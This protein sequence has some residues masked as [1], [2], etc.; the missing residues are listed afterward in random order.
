M[1]WISFLLGFISQ[2]QAASPTAQC[3]YE[4]IPDLNQFFIEIKYLQE[5]VDMK[6]IM[7]GKDEKIFE[8]MADVSH[9]H[10]SFYSI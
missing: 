7:A 4:E 1:N 5:D 6:K 8:K 3:L 9:R 2:I 10:L